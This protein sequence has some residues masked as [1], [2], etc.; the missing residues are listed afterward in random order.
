MRR[1]V[2]FEHPAGPA[3]DDDQAGAPEVPGVAPP[4]PVA[5]V[6]GRLGQVV[7]HL[8]H[9]TALADPAPGL[10]LV[11]LLDREVPEV[12]VD[13]VGD[14]AGPASG[15]PPR[16]SPP[17]PR[18]RRG[19]C[20]SR[21]P[22]RGRPRSSPPRRWRR[23][24]AGAGRP[25]LV[26]EAGVLLDVDDLVPA[27]VGPAPGG[28]GRRPGSRAPRRRRRPGRRAGAGSRASSPGRRRPSRGPAPAGR[29]GRSRPRAR[30]T[31]GS[32]VARAGR[33]PGRTRTPW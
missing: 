12:L 31:G 21:R 18:P 13:P 14:E 19:R 25:G 4:H 10:V 24:S 23:A 11:Q 22:C 9:L 32:T 3:L 29:R 27:L 20:S 8:G 26:V 28:S 16:P 15:A 5:G 17:S 2:G 33:S 30:P 6:P 7:E 1:S